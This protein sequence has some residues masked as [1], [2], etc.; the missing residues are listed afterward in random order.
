[1]TLTEL[2]VVVAIVVILASIFLPM[3]RRNLR[4]QKVR[5]ATRQLNVFV[6]G[7]QARAIELGRPAGIWIERAAHEPTDPPERWYAAYTLYPAEQPDP[8]RGDIFDARVVIRKTTPANDPQWFAYYTDPAPPPGV[9]PLSPCCSSVWPA[10][11]ASMAQNT[12]DPEFRMTPVVRPGDMIRFSGAGEFYLI[13][14]V[15]QQRFTFIAP[16]I[17]D[18]PTV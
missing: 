12:L 6:T 1:M 13:T 7:A 18:L 9:V 17:V 10:L 11:Q 2:L 16:P 5:E 15:D 4:G 14:A 3:V 8:Y